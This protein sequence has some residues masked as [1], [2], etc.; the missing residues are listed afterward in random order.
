MQDHVEKA[1]GYTLDLQPAKGSDGDWLSAGSDAEDDVLNRVT[2]HSVDGKL[3]Q[4]V[5]V[6]LDQILAGETEP[7]QVLKE[8]DL[9]TAYYRVAFGTTR[10]QTIIG[11][12][13][14]HLSHKRPLRVLEVGAGTGGTTSVILKALGKAAQASNRL[15]TYVFTDLSSGFFEAAATDFGN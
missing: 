14:K 5:G 10:I 6:N 4:R 2:E 3:L 13:V 7:L 9:L 8:D 15:V 12:Y 1:K 11:Q